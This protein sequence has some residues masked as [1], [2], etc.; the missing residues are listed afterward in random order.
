MRIVSLTTAAVLF[1]AL[2][3][4]QGPGGRGRGRAEEITNRVGAFFTDVAGPATDGDKVAD[5]ATIDLVRA[6]TAAGQLTVLY[7]VDG[8]EDQDV[9]EQFERQVFAGDEL[10]LELRCFHCGRI[11]L[12]KEPALKARFAKQAPLFVLFDKDGKADELSMSGYKAS[13]TQLQKALEKAAGGTVK[14]SLASFAKEYA[15]LVRDLEQVLARKKAAQEKQA[16]AGADKGKRAEA[17][18]DLKDAEAEERK[19]LDKEKGLID[20]VRLPERGANAQRLGGSRWGRPGRE[21][22][23]EGGRG[24]NGG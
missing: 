23:G 1:A 18:K 22:R 9:R 13:A 4:A 21:G 19:L 8:S 2:A 11:D 24:G 3:P 10:G 16:K 14:P 7:L 6:A 15:G 12:Q 17:D 5:L 20:H